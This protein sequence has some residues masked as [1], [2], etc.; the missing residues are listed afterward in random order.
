MRAVCGWVRVAFLFTVF[1]KSEETEVLLNR[2]ITFFGENNV[3]NAL[4]DHISLRLILKANTI[5]QFGFK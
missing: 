5:V 3:V 2:C 1:D 4:G